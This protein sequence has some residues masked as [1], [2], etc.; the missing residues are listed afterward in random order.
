LLVDAGYQPMCLGISLLRLGAIGRV[1]ADDWL[2]PYYHDPRN[3]GHVL[4]KNMARRFA[5][6][7]GAWERDKWARS[8]TARS[9]RA[10]PR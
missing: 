5:A 9:A 1:H 4:E 8:D 6:S 2:I 7:T 3:N 10:E